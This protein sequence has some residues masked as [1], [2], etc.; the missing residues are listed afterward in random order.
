MYASYR[1]TCKDASYNVEL[2]GPS[3]HQFNGGK[4][5][6]SNHAGHVPMRRGTL[7]MSAKM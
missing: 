3:A 4:A 2:K 1:L 6:L 5:I 7:E